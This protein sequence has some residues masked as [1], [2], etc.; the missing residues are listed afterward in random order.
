[1][2]IKIDW[3]KVIEI[4]PHIEGDDVYTICI[5]FNDSQ[6]MSYAYNNKEDFIKDYT[7]IM[8]GGKL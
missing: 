4:E 7:D 2:N 3:D 1:M 8:C 6:V 5:V